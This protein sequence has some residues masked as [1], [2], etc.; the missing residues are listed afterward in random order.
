[1]PRGSAYGRRQDVPR[2][3]RINAALY[4]WRTGYIR[5]TPDEWLSPRHLAL[6]IPDLRAFHIDS[7][8]DLRLA[9][10]VLTTG[11]VA[12]PWLTAP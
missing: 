6:E 8:E 12:L 10:L 11:L 5:S 4:L 2:V 3:L 1:M 7:A 9:E